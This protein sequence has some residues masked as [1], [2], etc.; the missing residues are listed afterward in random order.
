MLLPL[1]AVECRRCARAG[2]AGGWS[3]RSG[4]G[5]GAAGGPDVHFREAFYAA[6]P[7]HRPETRSS[8]GCPSW[9]PGAWPAEQTSEDDDE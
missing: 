8:S 9:V 1:H 5:V 3:A 7:S 6:N 4:V 2:P